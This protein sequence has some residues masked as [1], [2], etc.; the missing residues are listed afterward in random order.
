MLTEPDDS[1]R[2]VLMEIARVVTPLRIAGHGHLN[3]LLGGKPH[4]RLVLGIEVEFIPTAVMHVDC[5]LAGPEIG[6]IDDVGRIGRRYARN[7]LIALAE[8]GGDIL[9]GTSAIEPAIEHADDF[10]RVVLRL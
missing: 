1:A 7:G 2:Q 10:L 6:A 9:A 3:A 8:D 5:E 4:E